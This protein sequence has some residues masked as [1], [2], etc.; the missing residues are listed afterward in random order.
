LDLERALMVVDARAA[1]G[2]GAEALLSV[3]GLRTRFSTSRGPVHAVNGVDL[4]LQRGET[5]SLVGE[6]GCGKS[7]T[8][9]SLLR[10]LPGE[11]AQVAAEEVRFHGLDLLSLDDEGMRR[12]LGAEIGMIFQ[13]PMSSLNPT[14][15]IGRQLTEGLEVHRRLRPRDARVRAGELLRSVGIPEPEARLDDYPHQFSGGMCQRVMIAV[16]L[17][18]GPSL[19][20]A[21]EPTTALDVTVQAQILDLVE[22]LQ[23]SRDMAIIW[24]S[25]DL[26]V[27]AHLSDRVAV[28]YGGAIVEEAP[29]DRLF[30][31]P[32]HPYTRGLLSSLPTLDGPRAESLAV[33]PGQPPD[34]SN[35]PVG[36]AFAPR[37]PH[38]FAR[39]RMEAP[40]LSA[41]DGGTRVAC[42]WDVDADAPRETA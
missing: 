36:C 3:R 12:I 38:A 41:V 28:M 34:M 14:L 23:T 8:V 37:C 5:L 1:D 33:V 27:V 24:I 35:E 7:A 19:L 26:S 31:S 4:S 32:Q 40:S 17:S 6:S 9:L 13:D 25:H 21:D 2:G 10:L 15:T 29:A 11:R 39:C 22:E 16:A 42:W 30:A 18:C 20:I